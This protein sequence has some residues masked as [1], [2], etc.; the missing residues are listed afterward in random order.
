MGRFEQDDLFV[1]NVDKAHAA[2]LKVGAYHYSYALDAQQALEEVQNCCKTIKDSGLSLELPVF[3]DMEDADGW[4]ARHN[5]VFNKNHITE[6]CH[7]FVKNMGVDCGVYASYYWL[8]N[9]IDWQSLQCPIWN[10]QWGN[11]DDLRGYMWQYTDKLKI[12]RNFFD[13]D[14]FYNSVT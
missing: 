4:K 12:G 3:Y 7:V 14:F 13:G 5:F 2:G 10:A 9:Y 1:S 8:C 11:T 6:M